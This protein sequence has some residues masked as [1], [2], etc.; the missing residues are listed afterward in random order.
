[1]SANTLELKFYVHATPDE[2]MELLT[3]PEF[4]RDWSG[5]GAQIE[6]KKGGQ[7][8]M[9]DGWVRGNVLNVGENELSYTWK[10]SEWTAE[11]PASVVRYRLEAA[12]HGTTVHLEHSG[13]PNDEEKENYKTGWEEFFFG[14]IGEYLANRNL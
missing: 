9:F 10:P 13:F 4:I 12:D 8:V 3:N 14:P 7:F 5:Q 1:M 6:K 11:T 2:V